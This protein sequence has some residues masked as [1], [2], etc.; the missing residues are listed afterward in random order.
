MDQATVHAYIARYFEDQWGEPLDPEHYL[1]T[2]DGV[3]L[4]APHV[5]I[6]RKIPD[7]KLEIPLHVAWGD[8]I[9]DG[10]VTSL[11]NMPVQVNGNFS[12]NMCGL[13]TLEHGPQIVDGEYHC[14]YNQ[15]TSL[16]H[17]PQRGVSTLICD[18]NM[19]K[20]LTSAPPCDYLSVVQN[21][22][23]TI[24]GVP[25]HVHIVSFTVTSTLPLLSMVDWNRPFELRDPRTNK[26]IKDLEQ[27]V[28]KYTGKGKAVMLNFALE[29][30]KH[31]YAGNA[32]W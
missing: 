16:E 29:L 28:I 11:H 2:P 13:T 20:D 31:G 32:R 8:L 5:A 6:N 24:H 27:I 19:L 1:I 26:R 12:C 4:D 25:D 14:S 3:D 7:G 18:H 9:V 21:P 23:N 15:L 22:L 17:A 10:K 30:K